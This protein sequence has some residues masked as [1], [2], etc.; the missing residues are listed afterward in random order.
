MRIIAGKYRNRNLKTD[1]HF[2][3]TTD[4]VRETLFNILQSELEGSVFVDAYSGSGA[5]GIEALS[6]GARM[7]YFLETHRRA[8]AVIESNL[9]QCSDGAAWRIYSMPAPRAL[10]EVRKHESAV[11]LIFFDPPY[12]FTGYTDLLQQSSNLFPEAVHILETSRRSVYEIPEFLDVVKDRVIGETRLAF[13][14][15]NPGRDR[16]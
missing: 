16:K 10:E 2:R 13:F 15:A 12:N 11:D 8:L 6:R 5:V 7:V 1:T 14:K 4:R 3:P 9:L